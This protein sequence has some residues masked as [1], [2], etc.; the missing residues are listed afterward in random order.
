MKDIITFNLKEHFALIKGLKIEKQLHKELKLYQALLMVFIGMM[1]FL[2]IGVISTLSV[3]LDGLTPYAISLYFVFIGVFLTMVFILNR[4]ER[5]GFSF[6]K[7]NQ[8]S[9]AFLVE[10]KTLQDMIENRLTFR[11]QKLIKLQ[12]LVFLINDLKFFQ[13]RLKDSFI[14]L[15]VKE[16]LEFFEQ[17]EEALRIIHKQRL[18]EQDP[19][20]V[21]GFLVTLMNFY[22]FRL[23]ANHFDDDKISS[24]YL[25]IKPFYEEELNKIKGSTQKQEDLEVKGSTP[26]RIKLIQ[27]LDK[28]A[29][30][31]SLVMIVVGFIIGI[32]IYGDQESL[33]LLISYFFTA[34]P[35]ALA[36]MGAAKTLQN[37]LLSR[38]QDS[39]DTEDLKDKED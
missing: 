37:Q 22:G 28:I 26:F 7:S 9:V 16:E 13:E 4:L 14:P 32:K 11:L 12:L 3:F 24:L 5:I 25:Q 38:Y 1:L 39:L 27:H 20:L 33:F 31:V 21:S 17:T 18:Y 23:R 35:G 36:L 29:G 10:L 19:A 8:R 15:Q 34:I 30:L 2:V 6:L